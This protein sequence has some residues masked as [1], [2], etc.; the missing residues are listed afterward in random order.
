M[1]DHVLTPV[2][3]GRGRAVSPDDKG[4]LIGAHDHSL[5]ARGEDGQLGLCARDAHRSARICGY[6]NACP[7]QQ[8]GGG[9]EGGVA[10]VEF[11]GL[12]AEDVAGGTA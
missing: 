7:G 6:V 10:D 3:L 12:H 5:P 8:C 9:Q 2:R 11:D 1:Q 4:R